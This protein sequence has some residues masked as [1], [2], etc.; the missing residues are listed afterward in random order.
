VR[1]IQ[2][3]YDSSNIT[4][5]NLSFGLENN[6]I[7]NHNSNIVNYNSINFNS[8]VDYN[9]NYYET[10]F[11]IYH[12][13]KLFVNNFNNYNFKN[14]KFQQEKISE[15]YKI[16]MSS[17]E[18]REDT[19]MKKLEKKLSCKKSDII[20]SKKTPPQISYDRVELKD[21]KILNSIEIDPSENF[22]D[23]RY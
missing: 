14:T 1:K 7:N 8:P 16:Y 2:Y 22:K 3:C 20:E 17:D 18:E 11:D 21:N 5:K 23:N 9:K 4:K 6:N 19:K 12:P 15:Q 13:K 10:N